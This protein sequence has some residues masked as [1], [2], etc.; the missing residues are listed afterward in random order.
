MHAELDQKERD[1]VMRCVAAR[2]A[3]FHGLGGWTIRE[4][5]RYTVLCMLGL[6]GM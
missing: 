6:P 2:F 4:G 3:G 1:L 5:N